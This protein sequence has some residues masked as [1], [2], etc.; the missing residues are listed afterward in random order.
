MSALPSGSLDC[1]RSTTGTF[2][3]RLSP[4]SSSWYDTPGERAAPGRASVSGW[5]MVRISSSPSS[6]KLPAR[7][8]LT[9]SRLGIVA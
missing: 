7:A 5:R 3:G 6:T 2:S 9:V 8:T 4:S 1:R